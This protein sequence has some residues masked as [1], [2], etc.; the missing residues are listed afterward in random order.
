M[1]YNQTTGQSEN[2]KGV[3][4]RVTGWGDMDTIDYID[5]SWSAYLLG[6]VG[7]YFQPMSKGMYHL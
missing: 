6:N 3:S 5:P 7:A 4:T 1:E 2:L